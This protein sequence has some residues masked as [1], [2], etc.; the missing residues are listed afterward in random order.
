[1]N[2]VTIDKELLCVMAT[3]YEFRSMLV[4]AELHVH[5]DHKNILSIGDSSQ[6][7]LCWISYVNE[8][9]P[10][11]QYVEGPR[12]VI[13]DTFSRL[14]WSKVSAPSVGKKATNV[15]SNSESNNRNESSH[16]LLMDDRAQLIVFWISHAF[17]LERK[18]KRDQQNAES[19]RVL[20]WYHLWYR[21][22]TIIF[23]MPLSNSVSSISLK[24]WLKTIL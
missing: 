22:E 21:M 3:L 7:C 13:S 5:T 15:F 20:Q 10:K 2:Y 12:N 18:R 19:V 9:G 11:L 14:L 16:S 24:T 17:L 1:M 23:A 6:Q 4:G 8:Y